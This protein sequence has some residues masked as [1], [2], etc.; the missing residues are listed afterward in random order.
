MQKNIFSFGAS[1]ASPAYKDHKLGKGALWQLV[2][3]NLDASAIC[4]GL[5]A[6]NASSLGVLQCTRGQ[7]FT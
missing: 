6:V 2:G 4:T 5:K 1:L 3:D 7:G